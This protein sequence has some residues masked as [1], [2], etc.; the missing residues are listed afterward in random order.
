MVVS[1]LNL[2]ET[3][4]RAGCPL[5][6]NALNHMPELTKMISVCENLTTTMVRLLPWSPST[7]YPTETLKQRNF[8]LSLSG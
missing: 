3:V 2:L 4:N 5:H 6:S 7:V 8:S 1:E